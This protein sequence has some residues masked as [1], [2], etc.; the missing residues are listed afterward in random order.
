[1]KRSWTILKDTREKKPLIFPA[2]LPCLDDTSP[3]TSK[4]SLTVRLTVVDSTLTTGDYA[5][6]GHENQVLVER[7]GCLREVAGNCLTKDGRRRFISQ[8]DRLKEAAVHPYLMLEGSPCELSKPVSNVPKPFLALDALQRIL[9]ERRVPLLL[10]PSN[11]VAA[12]RALGEWVARLLINGAL[13]HGMEDNDTGS[14]G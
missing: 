1:M 8:V 7:K 10:L 13:T 6:L 9:L 4:N 3:P 12:R 14:S 11:T 5:L 2:T